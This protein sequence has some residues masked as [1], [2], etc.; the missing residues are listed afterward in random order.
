MFLNSDNKRSDWHVLEAGITD[1]GLKEFYMNLGGG[2]KVLFS[3]IFDPKSA[4]P[5]ISEI[6]K[7]SDWPLFEYLDLRVEGKGF[8]KLRGLGA[9]VIDNFSSSTSPTD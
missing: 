9:P 6:I 1:R 4:E 8:Y 5:I 2:Q 7:S 3:T